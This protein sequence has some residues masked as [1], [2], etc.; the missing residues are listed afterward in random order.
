MQKNLCNTTI[1]IILTKM[2]SVIQDGTLDSLLEEIIR[3]YLINKRHRYSEVAIFVGKKVL[4]DEQVISYITLNLD[5][6]IEYLSI[7]RKIV[8]EMIDKIKS[9]TSYETQEFSCDDIEI[10]LGKLKDHLLLEL[11]R[12]RFSINREKVIST[13]MVNELNKSVSSAKDRLDESTKQLEDKMNNSVV[14]SLGI[15]SAVILSFFGGLSVLGSVFSNLSSEKVSIYR[16]SF[17][18]SLTGFILFN[19]IFLLLYVLGK[20][21]DKNIG[22]VCSYDEYW[23]YIDTKKFHTKLLRRIKI[24]I[25]RFPII[26]IFNLIMILLMIGIVISYLMR[27]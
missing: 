2:S 26:I 14:S 11:E 20:I 25:K 10:K 22:G 21:L 1:E 15:F 3:F 5:M 6:I 9:N 23:N 12:I 27:A 4:S 8:N 19:V 13:N 24:V 18:S 17:M 16:L 7:N